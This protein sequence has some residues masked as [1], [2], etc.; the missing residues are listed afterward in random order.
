MTNRTVSIVFLFVAAV[1]TAGLGLA[2][3]LSLAA[4]AGASPGPWLVSAVTFLSFVG[5]FF[6]AREAVLPSA[7]AVPAWKALLALSVWMGSTLVVAA[8]LTW[9]VRP[10][11]VAF[12][13]EHGSLV[14]L[15]G[16]VLTSVTI[17][18]H[19]ASRRRGRGR[20]LP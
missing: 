15:L 4:R 5:V 1:A 14:I 10:V 8:G 16:C 11:M 12:G 20:A 13:L 9:A 7:Y 18:D 6:L 3:A 19:F 17:L 2:L